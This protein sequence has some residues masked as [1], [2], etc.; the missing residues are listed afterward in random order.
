MSLV[1]WTA[2]LVFVALA[3][4]IHGKK[5]LPFDVPLLHA[6]HD[7]SSPRLNDIAVFVTNLGGAPFIIVATLAIA[8]GLLYLKKKRQAYIV[9]STAGG[10][11]VMNYVLKLFFARDRPSLWQSIITQSSYSFP[12]GHAMASSA[13]AFSLIAIAWHTK[14]RVLAMILGAYYILIIGF[15]RIYLGVH[16]PSDVLAGWCISLIWTVIV[17]NV[18]R[19]RSVRFWR[20]RLGLR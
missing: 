11:A 18:F 10:A 17:Y 9:L 15:T 7:L 5:T 2:V 4:E 20:S 13:L 14:W 6:V 19:E 8:G 3:D 16:F 12:S 1:F